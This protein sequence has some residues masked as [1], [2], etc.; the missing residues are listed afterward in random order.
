MSESI[1]WIE[2]LNSL[3]LTFLVSEVVVAPNMIALKSKVLRLACLCVT[4][5][6]IN[7][8][9]TQISAIHEAVSQLLVVLT[10]PFL[11][12]SAAAGSSVVIAPVVVFLAAVACQR[13][14]HTRFCAGLRSACTARW[15]VLTATFCALCCV[16]VLLRGLSFDQVN[17]FAQTQT[18]ISNSTRYCAE[19]DVLRSSTT[20]RPRKLWV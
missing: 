13:A 4:T 11:A 7:V 5:V 17:P 10:A 16:A 18:H 15:L 9:V 3:S 14:L 20:V 1:A 19:T 12:V 6:A 2:V 8:V